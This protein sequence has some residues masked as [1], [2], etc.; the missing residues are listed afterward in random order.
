M[1]IRLYTFTKRHNSTARPDEN[2]T[3][4]ELDVTMKRN[5]S[6]NAP[7]FLL[8]FEGELPEYNYLVIPSLRLYYYI[9]DI[10]IGNNDV[11]EF[12]CKMDFLATAR[13]YINASTAFVKYSSSD[14]D[15]YL[16]DDRIQPTAEVTS[17]VSSNN[18]STY[19]VDHPEYSSTYCYL[20]TTLN[21]DYGVVHYVI[22]QTVL[23][24]LCR[25]I[26]QDGDSIIGGVKQIFADAKDAIIK[27]QL[28]P[29]SRSALGLSNANPVDI[30]LGGYTVTGVTGY[31][32]DANATYKVDDFVQIPSL[33][34]DFT[35]VEPYCEAKLHIPL[36]GTHDLSLA[37]LADTTKL[38]FRYICN[39]ATGAATCIIWKGNAALDNSATKIIGCFN[40]SVNAEIPLGYAVSSNPTGLVSGGAALAAAV[41]GSGAVTV[42]GIAAAVASFGSY[43]TKSASVIGAFGGQTSAYDSHRLQISVYKRG[44]SDDPDNLRVLYGRPCGKVKNITDL[45]GYCQTSQFELLAPFDDGIIQEVNRLMDAGVYLE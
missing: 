33:S 9:D 4:H 42:G 43:F 5:T 35:K 19:I 31:V 2:A 27:L 21:E 12:V 6:I 3:Y 24:Y 41:I 34:D 18:L 44:L 15:P 7:I 26:V 30:K 39:V 25:A 1:L 17:V 22:N 29:W 10:V 13:P 40:G 23:N 16:K 8:D 14:Y 45:S 36:L 38:Y 28:I 11:M 20:L 32:L 37:E